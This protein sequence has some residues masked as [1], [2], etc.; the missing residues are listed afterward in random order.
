MQGPVNKMMI[1]PIR[2]EALSALPPGSSLL[3]HGHKLMSMIEMLPN[4]IPAT[5]I[6]QTFKA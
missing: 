1:I 6:N 5:A 2:L 3:N 4:S